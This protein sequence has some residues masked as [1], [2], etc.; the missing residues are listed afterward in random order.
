M[1]EVDTLKRSICSQVPRTVPYEV[2]L[3]VETVVPHG[4]LLRSHV[5]GTAQDRPRSNLI[6]V[7][8]VAYCPRLRSGSSNICLSYIHTQL[9]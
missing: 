2:R 3:C 9:Q 5:I 4:E 1:Q 7:L 8:L 6:H